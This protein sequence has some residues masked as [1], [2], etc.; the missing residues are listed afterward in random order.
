LTMFF[1]Y[2]EGNAKEPKNNIKIIIL[3]HGTSTATS[4][5]DTANSLLGVK[6]AFGMNAPLD[7]KPQQ[8][9][10]KLKSYLKE[11]AVKSDILFLVDMGSLTN[12]GEEIEKELDIRT[13]TIPLVSTLHVVEATR[14][15]MMGYSLEEVYEDTLRVNELLATDNPLSAK[16]S[17][18]ANQETLAIVTLCTTGEGGAILIK[19][20]LEKHLK[21]GDT[22][23]KVIPVSIVGNESIA[24]KLKNIQEQYRLVCLVGSLKVDSDIPQFGINEVVSQTALPHIQKLIDIEIAYLNIGDTFANHLKNID[25]SLAL[26]GIKKFMNSIEA[27][28][29]TKIDTSV[30]IG[31]A[32]HI[33]CMI[34]RLKGGDSV[35][36]FE[37]K[38]QYIEEY[39]SLYNMVKQKCAILNQKYQI[40]ISE[41]EICHLMV[42]FNPQNY[43]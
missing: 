10:A 24:I 39:P 18:S 35:A 21:F 30:L 17:E 3:A 11:S 6:Y 14:K 42:F 4:M 34:D 12:F 41:D 1:V 32:I 27:D 15:A 29:N 40:T 7:E 43:V 5:A 31:I 8:V 25:G 13:K 19:S 23:I 16:E 20:I 22:P 33:G 9:I 38:Q 28:L 36:N 37:G 2:N 26:K